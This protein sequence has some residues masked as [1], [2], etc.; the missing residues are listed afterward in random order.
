VASTSA[1]YALTTTAGA[2][3]AV[4]Y[5]PASFVG[6][7]AYTMSPVLG[8]RAGGLTNGLPITTS[9]VLQAGISV[10]GNGAQQTSGFFVMTGNVANDPVYGWTQAGGFQASTRQNSQQVSFRA[11]GSVASL[12][13]SM[14]VDQN[15]LPTGT[16]GTNQNRFDDAPLSIY[17]PETAYTNVGGGQ[18]Y[19]FNQTST[20]TTAP[21]GLGSDHP[22]ALMTAYAGGILQTVTFNPSTATSGPASA[23]LA[24]NGLGTV[25][26]QGNASRMGATFNVSAASPAGAAVAAAPQF[27]SATFVFGSAN[28]SDLSNTQGL[29]S[30]RGTYIDRTNFG[31]RSADLYDGGANIEVSSIT[32]SAGTAFANSASNTATSVSRTGLSMVTANTVGANSTKFLSSISSTS[33]TPC[34]CEYTQWGFWSVDTFRTDNGRNIGYSDKGNLLTWVA[35]IPANAADIPTTG[36][37]TYNGHAIANISNNG[38]QYVAA[39]TFSNNVNFA[40]RTGQVQVGGLDA[41]TYN[42]TVN[43]Q[44]GSALFGGSLGSG[45]SNR[46]MSMG[47]QFFQG[48]PTNTTPLYGEMGGTISISGP[49]NYIGSGIFAGRKP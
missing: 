6:S 48:G 41:T 9:R 37:A 42:G 17:T 31:A 24:I 45:A 39:G 46:N 18:N 20:R 43:L 33:V 29:N 1:A 27:N 19:T 8:Y 34:T 26:L 22:N 14:T 35:G 40:T 13:S 30:A 5:L 15:G 25:F 44:P 23:P 38:S 2:G 32:D 4:P 47:G 49:N 28:P 36:S 16:F 21:A 7:G 12:P 10:V 3:S 11:Q